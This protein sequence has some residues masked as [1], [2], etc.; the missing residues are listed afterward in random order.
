[1]SAVTIRKNRIGRYHAFLCEASCGYKIRNTATND[2][3]MARIH[4][5]KEKV[6][7][8]VFF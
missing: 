3:S 2:R 5:I 7:D 8:N 6:P 1:M 4:W